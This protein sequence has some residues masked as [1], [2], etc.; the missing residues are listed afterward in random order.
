[1]HSAVFAFTLLDEGKGRKEKARV[2]GNLD[3]WG[4]NFGLGYKGVKV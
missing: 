2:S 1:M 3:S 4:L